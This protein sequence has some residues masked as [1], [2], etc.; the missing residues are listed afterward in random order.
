MFHSP[1][2][3]RPTDRRDAG[4]GQRR[5]RRSP[6]R[7][8]APGRAG[9]ASRSPASG[10]GNRRPSASCHRRGSGVG[11][12][13]RAAPPG[14]PPG[15]L[16]ERPTRL[17]GLPAEQV[18]PADRGLREAEGRGHSRRRSPVRR[19][20]NPSARLRQSIRGRA[21]AAGSSTRNRWNCGS[22]LAGPRSMKPGF[23]LSGRP[24]T[25]TPPPPTEHLWSPSQTGQGFSAET[26]VRRSRPRWV[27]LDH[28]G[29]PGCVPVGGRHRRHD[30][31]PV[32]FPGR[33]VFGS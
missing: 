5:R 33:R 11:Y 19:P 10:R 30:A 1:A 3:R 14:R 16:G 15:V 27:P 26:G 31:G 20:A 12:R 2:V 13:R 8:P 23:A 21:G 9:R 22:P 17:V 28:G 32:R 18:E 25:M 6:L 29:V 7:R 4:R 24:H